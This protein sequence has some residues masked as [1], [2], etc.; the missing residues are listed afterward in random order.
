MY[1]TKYPQ[2]IERV[3]EIAKYLGENEVRLSNGGTLTIDRFR[4][5]GISFG[6]HGGI[7]GIHSKYN[8]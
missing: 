6:M 4:D 7:D 1:Y 2:D 8:I 3:K 5:L